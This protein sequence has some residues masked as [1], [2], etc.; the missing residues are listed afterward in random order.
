M[1]AAGALWEFVASWAAKGAYDWARLRNHTGPW[2][3]PAQA[4]ILANLQNAGHV[5]CWRG[6]WKMLVRA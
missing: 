1:L 6:A 3:L 5:S 4:L 2:I